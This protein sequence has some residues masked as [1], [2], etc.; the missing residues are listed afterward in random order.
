MQL[1]D[2]LVYFEEI[3]FDP[4]QIYHQSTYS[5]RET[6]VGEL[7]LTVHLRTD[8]YFGLDL[9]KHVRLKVVEAVD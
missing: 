2:E 5:Y 7:L 4:D 9:Q 6:Q 3:L 1:G 8:C